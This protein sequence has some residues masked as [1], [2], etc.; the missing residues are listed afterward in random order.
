MA[1]TNT[2]SGVVAAIAAIGALPPGALL[3]SSQV[4]TYLRM[5]ESTLARM[6]EKG[7][8]PVFVQGAGQGGSISYVKKDLDAWL[9]ADS[10]MGRSARH[11]GT[12]A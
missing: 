8:G 9:A 10:A 4:A 3:T 12:G 7:T 11:R 5:S 1:T 6:R 2:Q